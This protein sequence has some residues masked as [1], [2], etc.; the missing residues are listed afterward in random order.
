MSKIFIVLC[1]IAYCLLLVSGSAHAQENKHV[2]IVFAANMQD[3]ANQKKVGY[4][5]LSSLLNQIRPQ[6]NTI[7][8]FGGGS[9]GPSP[10]A[11]FDRGSHII[12]ILNTLEPDL[13]AVRKREFSYYEDELSLRSEEAAFPLVVSN[14][15]DPLT[16]GNIE[17]LYNSFIVE[18]NGHKIGFM[19]VLEEEVVEEYLLN[20]VK[21]FESQTIIEGQAKKLRLNGA[22]VVVMIFAKKRLYYRELLDLGI[23]D[24]AIRAR[25]D[26][27]N[28]QL[29]TLRHPKIYSLSQDERALILDLTW[30][31]H[32][33]SKM[34]VTPREVLLADYPEDPEVTLQINEYNHRLDRLLNQT[35][36]QL[37]THMKTLRES[38]RTEENA[39]ANFVADTIR[40]YK[41]ADIGLINGGVIRGDKRYTKNTSLTRRDIASELPFR[42]RV[43]RLSATGQQIQKAL[44]HGVA[45]VELIRGKFPQ[46]SGMSYQFSTSRK[47]GN[48]VSKILING[49]KLNPNKSYTVATSDYIANGGDGFSSFANQVQAHSINT[50]LPLISDIVILRIQ[51]LRSIEMK[52]EQR[53]VRLD[54]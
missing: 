51:K 36:G 19:S 10:M 33:T 43:I 44:E 15:I 9:L 49:K 27:D 17:G 35:I 26:Q 45:E 13:M 14:I 23:V 21:V 3:I 34:V 22:E 7:F 18:K 6:K 47:P 53:I 38:V 32:S 1:L 42:S 20:R 12:D 50:S 25:S 4:S 5:R 11:S 41:Q 40:E 16:T 54:K 31:S 39:F 8:A 52:L 37:T 30:P 24:I 48:R 2:Q 46:V 29:N 28:A